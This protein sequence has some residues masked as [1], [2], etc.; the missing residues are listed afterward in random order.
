MCRWRMKR[1]SKVFA[2]VAGSAVAG[3]A[4]AGKDYYNQASIE[5]A[6]CS[7]AAAAADTGSG[8][9]TD[10]VVV[11]VVMPDFAVVIVGTFGIDPVFADHTVVAALV[12]DTWVNKVVVVAGMAVADASRRS[13]SVSLSD[14]QLLE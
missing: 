13:V 12:I 2:V 11:V 14:L 3:S 8:T 5:A 10:T 7:R 4:A 9:D 6:R 1:H